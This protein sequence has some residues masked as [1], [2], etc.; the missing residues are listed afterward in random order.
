VALRRGEGGLLFNRVLEEKLIE[1][2]PELIGADNAGEVTRRIE[3]MRNT[4]E[5]NTEILAWLRG[6]GR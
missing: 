4:I 5:E 1:L 6:E 2:N 3:A